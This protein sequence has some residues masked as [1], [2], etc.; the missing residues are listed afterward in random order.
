M[1]DKGLA[2]YQEGEALETL[3]KNV[4]NAT[5]DT[6]TAT[7]I[8]IDKIPGLGPVLGPSTPE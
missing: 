2:Y 3:M 5:K 8:L 4:V 1:S 7:S 6:L